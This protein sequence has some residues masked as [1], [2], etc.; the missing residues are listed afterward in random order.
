MYNRFPKKV[1]QQYLPGWIVLMADLAIMT[2]TFIFTYLLRFNLVASSASLPMLVIQLCLAIPLF[3]TGAII[4][5]PHYHIIR[6]TTLFDVL[7]VVKAHL[8]LTGGL[9]AIRLISSQLGLALIIPIS[10]IIVQFFLSVSLMVIMRYMI[11]VV[12]HKILNKPKNLTNV[13]IYGAGKLGTIIQTIINNDSN[14]NYRI[15]GF[16]DDNPTLWKSRLG[17][18]RI[19]SSSKVFAHFANCLEVKEIILAISPE[20]I[21]IE[22]KRAIVDNCLASGI[23]VRE[24]SDPS[25]WL[26]KKKAG[27]MITNVKIEDLLGRDPISINVEKVSKG[28]DGKRVMITGGAGSIGS[29]MVR[30]L[31]FLK[32]AAIVIVDQAESA[33]FDIQ[34]EVRP[35][36]NGI[37]LF[38][39]VADVTDKHKMRKIFER[40]QPD[41]IYHAAAYKHVPMMELQPYEAILNNIGGTKT[42][43]DLAVEF[44]VEK[45][46][47]VS[48]DKAVNPTN[49]MGAS[50]RICEVYIQ[51][52]SNQK[53]LKTQF[54]TTR[55]GNVL[56]SNGS[57]IPIFKNQ[58]SKGGPV[59]IT[60]KD[61]I[62][63][64]MT[65]PEACQLVL[66]AGFLGQGG[67]IFLFDMGEP[68]KIYDLAKKMISL[69]GYT[70]HQDIEIVEIGLRPGE[71]LFEELLADKETTMPTSNKRIMIAKIR[72]YQ[73]RKAL[74]SIN[75]MLE[76]L[77][78]LDDYQLVFTMKEIVPEF[79]SSNSKF[80]TLDIKSFE[81]QVV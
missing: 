46:V 54:I 56:G 22:A 39:F 44:E 6:H 3:I 12:F 33:L 17:G 40:C 27:N 62:R 25:S 2:C 31:L 78:K 52:L 38:G 45:F 81:K 57:V 5:K 19:Y 80:E 26:D 29:E 42:L 50:K 51:S 70:P 1:Y 53:D 16:V 10:V 23:K 15:V 35:N 66:E 13:L 59:T 60:H 36:L 55:F 7:T 14:L 49:I 48:T 64:F 72:P 71:K 69:S 41:I 67:E 11:K 47:M 32:P 34:N 73:Y 24:V 18:V 77:N 65:I 37:E 79:I 61:V 4:F 43:A 9:F 75:T 30:Q 76:E 68:V 63:Y 28:I 21:E 20:K 8:I 58:I 74:Q